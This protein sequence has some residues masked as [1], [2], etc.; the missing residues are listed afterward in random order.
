MGSGCPEGEY[1]QGFKMQLFTFYQS[2]V[3]FNLLQ[4]KNS[5]V[6]RGQLWEVEVLRENVTKLSKCNFSL[7]HFICLRS[8]SLFAEEKSGGAQGATKGSGGLKKSLNI[9]VC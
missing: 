3:T 6:L 1:Y 7:S 2:R 5:A 9:E 4:R 8:L